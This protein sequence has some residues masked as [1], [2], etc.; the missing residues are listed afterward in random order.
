MSEF[1]KHQSANLNPN[2]KNVTLLAA[3]WQLRHLRYRPAEF[4]RHFNLLCFRH[5]MKIFVAHFRTLILRFFYLLKN[6]S[7]S[8]S[9]A[10]ESS[11]IPGTLSSET[12]TS[13]RN[14]VCSGAQNKSWKGEESV[15]SNRR[16]DIKHCT[17]AVN[18]TS[19]CIHTRRL[20]FLK[21]RLRNRRE[22]DHWGDLGVGG[23]IILGWT[24]RRWDVGMW[25]GS[26]WP[27]I[28][29][30]GGRLWVR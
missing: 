26:G 21:S 22:R 15:S 2:R 29:T 7:M 14:S 18:K 24:S 5:R 1:S 17:S 12:K 4:F 3:E 8:E 25:T 20:Q 27:R 19:A 13:I 10:L 28:G 11:P 6:L 16:S 23:W 30:G 9:A